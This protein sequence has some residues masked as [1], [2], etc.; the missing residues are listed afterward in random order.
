[1][2]DDL[3]RAV[4]GESSTDGWRSL[5]KICGITNA[6]DAFMAI[7]NGADAL[8][9]NFCQHSSRYIELSE[10]RPWLT[11]LP[12]DIVKIAV[13]VNPTIEQAVDIATLPFIDALQLHGDESPDFCRR[14]ASRGH[15]FLKAI[16]V[17]NES[18]LSNLPSY[19]TRSLLLDSRSSTFGGSGQ[20][21]PWLLAQK[22]VSDHP[23]LQVAIAGGLTAENVT[24]AVEQVRPFAVDVTTGV[25]SSPGRK[26]PGQL[27]HFIQAVR[28]VSE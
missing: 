4:F 20:T 9:F 16:G 24:I 26:N 14:L 19:W 15:A 28:S 5:V 8:G 17:R 27:K 11:Q 13:L 1:V 23:D 3:I 12:N 22:F 18:S 25:E 21:F 6:A 7:E 2:K 10:A